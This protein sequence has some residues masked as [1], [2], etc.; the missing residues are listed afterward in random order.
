MTGIQPLLMY[1]SKTYDNFIS[2]IFI[3][4]YT[5]IAHTLTGNL[6]HCKTVMDVTFYIMSD[7]LTGCKIH[8]AK[9]AEANDKLCV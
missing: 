7:C 1:T 3:S 5:H 4:S 6:N 9:R 8:F 2:I